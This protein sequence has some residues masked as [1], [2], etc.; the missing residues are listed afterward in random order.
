MCV[1]VSMLLILNLSHHVL[2][3]V[4]RYT[5]IERKFLNNE[6]NIEKLQ[7]IF[8]PVNSKGTIFAVV[9][10]VYYDSND[11]LVLCPPSHHRVD[12][13]WYHFNYGFKE[14]C[15]Q[16]EK[17]V[18]LF[19]HWSWTDSAV[20]VLYSPRDIQ[21]LAYTV[22]VMFPQVNRNLQSTVT[23]QVEN[24]CPNVTYQHLLKLTSRVM[25]IITILI[26]TYVLLEIF[27]SIV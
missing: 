22:N 16:S 5:E 6:T 11:T 1:L 4:S 27:I 26:I 14:N 2:G 12:S 24:I 23:L 18:S 10:Y 17:D 13:K 8:F 20:H 15:V 21:V 25:H 3:C 9:S 7:D 19:C